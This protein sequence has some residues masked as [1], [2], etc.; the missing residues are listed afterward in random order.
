MDNRT[1]VGESPVVLNN[2]WTEWLGA[3][4]MLVVL[5]LLLWWYHHLRGRPYQLFT[6]NKSLAI[7]QVVGLCL[8]VAA[9]PFLRLTGR[10]RGWITLRR[11]TCILA[12]AGLAAHGIISFWFLP[13]QF[14]WSYYTSHVASSI[15][16]LAAIAGLLFL[17]ALSYP[18]AWRL[19]GPRRWKSLQL[20]AY[21]ILALGVTHFMLLDK[22]PNWIK[23]FKTFQPALPPGTMLPFA[24]ACL[25]VA[26]KLVDLKCHG[27][28]FPAK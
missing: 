12:V 16:G 4:V 26:V 22:F 18:A 14:P 20:L 21:P 9:G 5:V 6:L 15:M 10:M 27:Q 25:L 11:P 17:W 3:S 13:K 2:R 1:D 19:L 23:W 28:T 8:A 7:G 24:I